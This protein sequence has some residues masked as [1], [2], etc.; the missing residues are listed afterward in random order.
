VTVI[1][2][3]DVSR[4]VRQPV[5]SRSRPSATVHA[6]RDQ[7][8]GEHGEGSHEGKAQVPRPAARHQIF[9]RWKLWKLR[10]GVGPRWP[11]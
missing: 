4:N 6:T 10:L 8:V 9:V 1:A 11:W 7:D 5:V 2:T 3:S